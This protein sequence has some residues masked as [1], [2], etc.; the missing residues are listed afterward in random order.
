M[1]VFVPPPRIKP[2]LGE[3][4]TPLPYVCSCDIRVLNSE[5][6]LSIS[7]GAI[8]WGALSQEAR[9]SYDRM[10]NEENRKIQDEKEQKG[11][12]IATYPYKGPLG[13]TGPYDSFMARLLGT[14]NLSF[15]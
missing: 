11:Y 7:I 15:R 10:A 4:G 14:I 1:G 6:N 2:F 3:F 13:S 5:R 12:R 9:D 8:Q